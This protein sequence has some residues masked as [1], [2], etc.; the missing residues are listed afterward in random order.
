MQV[1]FELFTISKYRL[2]CLKNFL[3]KYYIP[4][5]I[6]LFIAS[7]L[8]VHI[9]GV[10]NIFINVAPIEKYKH[11]LEDKFLLGELSVK[12]FLVLIIASM[13]DGCA[14]LIFNGFCNNYSFLPLSAAAYNILK[15]TKYFF[16]NL[17]FN[18]IIIVSLFSFAT[19]SNISQFIAVSLAI[20]IYRL[21][22]NIL[23]LLLYEKIKNYINTAVLLA[24]MAIP[25][26]FFLISLTH[27]TPY[28]Y[29]T[30]SHEYSLKYILSSALPTEW[31]IRFIYGMKFMRYDI[32][33][34]N[35]GLIILISLAAIYASKRFLTQKKMAEQLN[36]KTPKPQTVMY[37]KVKPAIVS[38]SR[39]LIKALIL[40]EA[41]Q[42]KW[43]A[44]ISVAMLIFSL[45]ASCFSREA[46][47]LIMYALALFI[48]FDFFVTAEWKH[49]YYLKSYPVS[50]ETIYWIKVRF[51][52]II[53]TGMFLFLTLINYV[54]I[55]NSHEYTEFTYILNLNFF[56]CVWISQFYLDLSL[57]NF[58]YNIAANEEYI[59]K[60]YNISGSQSC[61]ASIPPPLLYSDTE[62][63][64]FILK[65]IIA[66]LFVS[67]WIYF[68]N[69]KLYLDFFITVMALSAIHYAVHKK[70]FMRFKN[71]AI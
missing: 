6:L 63:Y 64:R 28:F 65:F 7:L 50:F 23:I 37:N 38:H 4:F 70:A 27:I 60:S 1:I 8:E 67:A 69:D 21:V 58:D 44:I 3:K 20:L 11:I 34:Y 9:K 42:Y 29:W 57:Y 68:L 43:G 18:F 49:I 24:L 10:F 33:F 13:F 52:L 12:L 41:V 66:I 61:D 25:I 55:S 59:S 40:R 47:I 22:F 17:F 45:A 14:K 2:I 48:Y 16:N 19:P 71:G 53:K 51:S 46:S 15:F 31:L 36:A 32:M 26:F 62:I 56:T 30:L 39:S 35:L 54:F 5:L